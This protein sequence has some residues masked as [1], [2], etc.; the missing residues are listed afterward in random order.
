[1]IKDF[2]NVCGNAL[3]IFI[4]LCIVLIMPSVIVVKAFSIIFDFIA[5]NFLVCVLALSSLSAFVVMLKSII[6]IVTM[7]FFGNRNE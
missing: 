5:I 2:L 6:T 1:M 7:G 4:T 3:V